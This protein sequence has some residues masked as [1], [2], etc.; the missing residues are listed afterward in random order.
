M[1]ATILWDN[2]QKRPS[3]QGCFLLLGCD[4]EWSVRKAQHGRYF[5]ETLVIGTAK[6]SYY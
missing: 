2:N 6:Q 3:T 4:F 5:D 1:W